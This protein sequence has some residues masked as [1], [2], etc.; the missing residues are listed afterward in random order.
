VD[1]Q[2]G[3]ARLVAAGAGEVEELLQGDDAV[4][5]GVKGAVWWRRE[6]EG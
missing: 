1:G 3:A 4:A 6:S 5:V 2:Q